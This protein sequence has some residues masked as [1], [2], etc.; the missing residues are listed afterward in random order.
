V[1][2]IYEN[3]RDYTPPRGFRASVERLLESLPD[4]YLTGI[5][6][7][8]LTN[9]ATASKGKTHRI[10]GRKY[11]R[12]ECLGTYHPARDGSAAWIELH[13][14]RIMPLELPWWVRWSFFVDSIVGSTLYHEV[15]HHLDKTIGSRTRGGE[16][17]ADAWSIDLKRKHFRKRFRVLLFLLNPFA[18]FI[19]RF[20]TKKKGEF[21]KWQREETM[22]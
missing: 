4:G 6:S 17:A 1:I 21:E 9:S 18:P 12:A 11:R 3:F 14:D 19:R 2:P 16:R 15:G 13:V 20:V 10:G 8:V 22:E 7:V 5:E